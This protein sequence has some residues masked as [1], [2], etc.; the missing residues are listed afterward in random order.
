MA[1]KAFERIMLR[2]DKA[3]V[4]AVIAGLSEI[5]KEARKAIKAN[6]DQVKGFCMAMGSASFKVVWTENWD[7]EPMPREENLHPSELSKSGINCQ[8]ADNIAKLLD[9]Y[10]GML[11]FTGYPMK[12]D[13]DDT[14]EIIKLK[15]W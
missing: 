1:N 6:P 7:G 14:G 8:H 2:I 9:E 15:D 12:L 11:R 5:E 4:K 13:R 10:N 3:L